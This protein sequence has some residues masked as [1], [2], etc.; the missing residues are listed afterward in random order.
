MG[1]SLTSSYMSISDL[2]IGLILFVG[3][4]IPGKMTNRYINFIL[5]P[6]RNGNY[7]RCVIVSICRMYV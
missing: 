7:Q 6:R 5:F 4:Y 3:Y 2:S 1:N